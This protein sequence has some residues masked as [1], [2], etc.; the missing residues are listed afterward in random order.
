MTAKKSGV[1]AP[2]S[3]KYGTLTDGAAT[4]VVTT[5][6][7]GS[8]KQVSGSQSPDGS[9]YFCLTDGAGSLV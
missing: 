3:A 7:S 8:A 2:D 5:T 6:S 4:L 1:Y 9:I